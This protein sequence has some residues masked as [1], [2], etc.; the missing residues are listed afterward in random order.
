MQ[1]KKNNVYNVVVIISII[2][3]LLT[4]ILSIEIKADYKLVFLLPCIY[5]IMLAISNNNKIIASN[6]GILII[7]IVMFI[8][9][10]IYPLILV[11]TLTSGS[12][13]GIGKFINTSVYLM[14]YE[15][16]T[17]FLILNIW[18]KR[19]LSDVIKISTREFGFYTKIDF[20]IL[21]SLGIFLFSILFHPILLNKYILSKDIILQKEDISGF[22]A[23][24]FKIGIYI[25]YLYI[26]NFIYKKYKKSSSIIAL[27]LSAL[28]SLIIIAGESNP[29]SESISRWGFLVYSL[30]IVMII[31]KL[32]S[33]YSKLIWRVSLPTILVAI[34]L[35]TFIKFKEIFSLQYFLS[36]YLSA[37]TLDS[38]FMGTGNVSIGLAMHELYARIITFDTMFTDMFSAVPLVSHFFDPNNNSTPV[39]Y[40]YFT[41]RTDNIIPTIVQSYSYFGFIGSPLFSILFTVLT[42][43][44]NRKL[45]ET[46]DVM[47]YFILSLLTISFALFMAI[48]I[49][50]IFEGT[51]Y[52]MIF[53]ILIV[54]NNKYSIIRAKNVNHLTGVY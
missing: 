47:M 16:I 48:N 45:N 3:F 34:V 15:C 35:L 20:F 53:I 49:N 40:H 33:N 21:I 52:R 14:I 39:F 54:I 26:L 32:Y 1:K 22:F 10:L 42:I 44:L 18:G 28:V 30:T 13:I 17:V 12:H 8:R 6:I 50:I 37:I 29:Q 31:A 51:W 43:E 4:Y 23:I 41:G 27:L 5:I 36:N 11:S 24:F 9:F 2:A 25:V 38:Y 46:R 19:R 7:N